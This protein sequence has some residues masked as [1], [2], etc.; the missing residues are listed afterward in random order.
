MVCV[1]LVGFVNL[2]LVEKL[3]DID[4]TKCLLGNMRSYLRNKKD[5]VLSVEGINPNSKEF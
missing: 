4:F 3:T 5:T 2:L 1:G